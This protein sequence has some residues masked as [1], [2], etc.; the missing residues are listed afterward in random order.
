[1]LEPR[2]DRL[3]RG[4]PVGEH[5]RV[6]TSPR[7]SARPSTGSRR[8]LTIAWAAASCLLVLTVFVQAVLAGQGLFG[9]AGFA[10]HGYVGNASFVLGLATA[11]F[12]AGARARG[13]QLAV[14]GLVLLMLFTQTGLGYVGRNSAEAAA[15]HVPLGV[16]TFSLVVLQAVAAVLAVGGKGSSSAADR[17]WAAQS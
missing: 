2:R 17:A 8:P 5:G 4:H 11:L 16:V 15:W 10:L 3:V 12:A 7:R 13:P 6:T 14:S 1:M 9:S